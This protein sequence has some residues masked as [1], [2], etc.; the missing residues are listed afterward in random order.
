MPVID[1]SSSDVVNG[2]SILLKSL[3]KD[4]NSTRF[5]GGKINRSVVNPYTLRKVVRQQLKFNPGRY[6]VS[7]PPSYSTE[8]LRSSSC[9][10]YPGVRASLENEMRAKFLGKLKYGSASLGMTLATYK[11][12]RAMIHK[13][14][15]KTSETLDDVLAYL[16]GHPQAL[17][18]IRKRREPLAG[19]FLEYEFGWV[20]L[21]QDIE[22]AY[23]TVIQHAAVDGYTRVSGKRPLVGT[24]VWQR[25]RDGSNAASYEGVL[26]ISYSA[27]VRVTNHN[28]WLAERAGLINW[29]AVAWDAVPW[30]F[31]VNMFVNTS[32]IIGSL[33]DSI[34]LAIDEQS[35]TLKSDFWYQTSRSD[36][37]FGSSSDATFFCTDQTRVKDQ[38]P[39]L[40]LEFRL[41]EVS[42]ELAAIAASLVVQKFGKINKLIRLI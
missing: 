24:I 29:A 41:P 15:M 10:G 38:S 34:G 11:E 31:V 8:L 30:S 19:Q 17:A 5:P 12:S 20:P 23:R 33:T 42:W 2:H 22:A 6:N 13:R 25:D 37:Y 26:R 1:I 35:L 14:L 32:Q 21:M 3:Y 4:S 27:Y 18:R 28:L 36:N 16:R 40:S 39:K 9:P 7:S